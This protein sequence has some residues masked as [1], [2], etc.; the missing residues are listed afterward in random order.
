MRGLLIKDFYCLKK[1][2][3]N[4]GFVIIG[5]IVISIMFVL[6]YNFG[7]I[8]TGF[9]QIVDSGQNTETAVMQMA[10]GAMLLFM[11]IPLLIGAAIYVSANFDKL[12]DFITGVNDSALWEL[13]DQA[14]E[15]IFHRSYILLIAAILVSGGTYFAAVHIAARKR[16]VA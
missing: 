4:Y 16:G 11:L 10:R 15:F 1:Q 3:I 5:V 7:N 13:Y 14:T 9:V 6:S 2:L 12:K 8:H